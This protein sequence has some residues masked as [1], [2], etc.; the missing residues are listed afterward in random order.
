MTRWARASGAGVVALCVL[1][2]AGCARAAGG[3]PVSGSAA[4]YHLAQIGGGPSTAD[5]ALRVQRVSTPPGNRY[6]WTVASVDP[7]SRQVQVFYTDGA[8]TSA[9]RLDLEETS[10][11]VVIGI[12]ASKAFQGSCIA[13]GIPRTTTVALKKPLGG[14]AL[15]EG[16]TGVNDGLSKVSNPAA[17]PAPVCST[18]YGT[19]DDVPVGMPDAASRIAPS[20][21]TKVFVCRTWWPKGSAHTESTTVTTRSR[22]AALTTAID[23]GTRHLDRDAPG[24][25]CTT[26]DSRASL[27]SLTFERPGTRIEVRTDAISCDTITNGAASGTMTPALVRTLDALFPA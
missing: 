27:Y 16:S 6:E 3:P 23:S 10:K 21:A 24:T 26:K 1:L 15:M 19:G 14:R 13:V 22:I 4:G 5:R 25:Q 2:L 7:S 9:D 18:G 11:T 12:T 17:L 20:A 8:C